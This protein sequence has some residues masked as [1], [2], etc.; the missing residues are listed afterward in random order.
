[1]NILRLLV[2]PFS[3]L[4]IKH[5]S[6]IFFKILW[7]IPIFFSIALTFFFWLTFE[8]V[9]IFGESGFLSKI[10]SFLQSLPGFYIAALA[11]I[12]TFG[13]KSLDLIMSG[14]PPKIN[15]D[16]NGGVLVDEPLTRRLFLCSMFSYL[17]ILSIFL[18]LIGIFGVVFAE[19]F[20]KILIFNLQIYVKI[21][22]MFLY[23]VFVV[24]LFTVTL[25]GIS[26]LGER[27]HISDRN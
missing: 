17:T 6:K 20:K 2:R 18:T 4:T 24:Q 11:A 19:S 8:E 27:M 16:F 13:S 1:M 26:Y 10:T 5:K 3:F 12:A 22:F 23:T 15:I 14:S 9:N 21:T 7:L 25:W